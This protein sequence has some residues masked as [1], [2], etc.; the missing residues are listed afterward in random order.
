MFLNTLNSIESD[1][2]DENEFFISLESWRNSAF[3]RAW[4]FEKNP[5]VFH[6]SN[7]KNEKTNWI[8]IIFE[9]KNVN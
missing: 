8:K 2:L 7:A 1:I 3:N 6:Y 5:L 9:K 4:N